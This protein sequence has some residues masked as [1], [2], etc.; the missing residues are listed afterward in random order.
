MLYLIVEIMFIL[1]N[2]LVLLHDN[3]A[4]DI[5]KP[6]TTLQ[7]PASRTSSATQMKKNLI[8]Q[9]KGEYI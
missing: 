5:L 4:K 9:V 8:E 3:L 2:A 7:T 1:M 6:S